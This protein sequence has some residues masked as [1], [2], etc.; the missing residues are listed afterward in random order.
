V[1]VVDGHALDALPVARLIRS[2]LRSCIRRHGHA[3]VLTLCKAPNL[4]ECN[5]W[6]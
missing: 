6:E 5:A 1:E 4:S 3:E 2:K